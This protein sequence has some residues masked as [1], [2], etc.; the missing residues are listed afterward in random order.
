MKKLALAFAVSLSLGGC[1]DL[2]MLG[3][4]I[5]LATQSIA[6]PITP[7]REAQIEAAFDA[8]IEVFRGYKNACVQGTADKNCRANIQAIQAYT[9]QMPPIL[10]QM[11]NF[12]DKNDQVNA[13]VAY[14]QFSTLYANL[15][16]AAANVGYNVGNLP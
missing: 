11:R 14:N 10:T 15:K 12:V 1:A 3:T 5:S 13:I 8:A 4:G 16:T 6:N 2:Q 7:T 9:R